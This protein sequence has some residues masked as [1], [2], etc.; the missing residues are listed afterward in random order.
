ME[1]LP[2]EFASKASI[3]IASEESRTILKEMGIE[4]PTKIYDKTDI[5][6]EL[7][8]TTR[9]TNAQKIEFIQKVL[10]ILK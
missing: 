8:Y 2:E 10:N 1:L 5:E 3:K 6:S 9:L 4:V 7:R